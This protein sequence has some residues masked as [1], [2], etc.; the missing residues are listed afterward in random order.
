MSDKTI[1]VLITRPLDIW[2]HIDRDSISKIEAVSDMVKVTDI[3]DF[4]Y[5]ERH[6]DFSSKE[7]LDTLFVEAD[8]IYGFL[9]PKDIISRATQLKWIHLAV[10][11]VEAD[12]STEVIDSKVVVTNSRGIHRTQVS[13]LIFAFMFMLAKQA[14]LIFRLKQEKRWQGFIPELLYSK[15]MTILGLGSIGKEVARLARAFNMKVVAVKAH[16]GRGFRYAD[17]VLP[18][19]RIKEALSQADFVV[20]LFPLTARTNNMIGESELRAMK[21]T[22]YFINVGRGKTVDED[23]LV[24]ALEEKW[25]AGAALDTFAVEP[26]PPDS[27]LWG[28]PNVIITSHIAGQREDY[29][30]L[31]NR[32]FCDNLKRYVEGKRLLNIVDKRAF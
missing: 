3:S 21:P 13:E 16:A 12:M 15:T 29:H 14:P 10:A 17:I 2:K 20:N 32:L 25:I 18:P 1:N 24:R 26:L 7:K 6:S 8:V 5:A 23:A 27:K 28:M 22:S 9:L 11:G 4:S 31:A 30:A 19:E